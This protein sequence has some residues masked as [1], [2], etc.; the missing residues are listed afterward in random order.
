MTRRTI[1]LIA[2]GLVLIVAGGS[3]LLY[4]GMTTAEDQAALAQAREAEKQAQPEKTSTNEEISSGDSSA[5][6]AED[7]EE[8]KEDVDEAEAKRNKIEK[9]KA[10]KRAMEAK[11]AL[12]NIEKERQETLEF[13]E[14]YD[15]EAARKKERSDSISRWLEKK[16][17]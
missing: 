3:A 2:I 10:E 12:D 14:Q 15:Q 11:Q 7:Q 5:E 4:T 1:I 9:Q 17:H 13:L 8:K 6:E 16:P